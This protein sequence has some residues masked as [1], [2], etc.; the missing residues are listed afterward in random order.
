MSFVLGLL[1]GGAIGYFI[2][3]YQTNVKA[4]FAAAEAKTESVFADVEK[5]L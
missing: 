2:H 1:I 4:D 5:K 3:M